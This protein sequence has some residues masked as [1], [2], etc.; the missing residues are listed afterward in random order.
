[1]LLAMT[2]GAGKGCALASPLLS[3]L[4]GLPQVAEALGPLPRMVIVEY[5]AQ[6]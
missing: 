2:V 3:L 5:S 6:L 1:M 4:A